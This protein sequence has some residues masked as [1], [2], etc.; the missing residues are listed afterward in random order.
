[1]LHKSAVVLAVAAGLTFATQVMAAE[2][3]GGDV[4]ELIVVGSGETRSVS[5]LAPAN[6]EVLPP[7]RA[8]RRR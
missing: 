4:E 2:A 3:D 5:T 8:S 7:A 6:L 1:M